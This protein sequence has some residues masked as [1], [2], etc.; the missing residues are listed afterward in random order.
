MA[1]LPAIP[2]ELAAVYEVLQLSAQLYRPGA[3]RILYVEGITGAPQLLVA[4]ALTLF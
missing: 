2:L 1:G 4:G 3:R